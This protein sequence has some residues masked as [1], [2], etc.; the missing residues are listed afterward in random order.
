M[1]GDIALFLLPF[2]SDIIICIGKLM[3]DDGFSRKCVHKHTQERKKNLFPFTF[4]NLLQTRKPS[5]CSMR[6]VV[7]ILPSLSVAKE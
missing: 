5:L 3:S 2:F 6:D 4:L 7:L 1:S